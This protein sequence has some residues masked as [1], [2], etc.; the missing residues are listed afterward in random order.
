MAA[1]MDTPVSV[2]ETAGEGG[3]WGIAVLASYMISKAPDET[4]AAYLND[5]VFAGN[6]G[7]RMEPLADDVKGFDVFIQ[8]YK[9]GFPM[10]HAAVDCMQ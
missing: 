7:S 5:R 4:L 1:A 10:E 9:A 2:M 6:R 8:N 3:A